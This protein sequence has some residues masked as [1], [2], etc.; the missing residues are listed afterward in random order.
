MEGHL[1]PVG[2]RMV[3]SAVSVLICLLVSWLAGLEEL[4]IY[5]SIAALQCIQPYA[6]DTWK[7][8]RQRLYGTA[9]GSVFGALAI[10]VEGYLLGIRGTLAGYVLIAAFIIPVLWAT[11]ALDKRNTA[12]FSCVVFLSIT[13]THITDAD[14]WLFVWERVSE[15]LAG[16]VVGIAVSAFQLPRRKRRDILFVSGLD[17]VLLAPQEEMTPYSR[18]RLNRML[19]DGM[20]FTIS[21]MRTP[22]SVREAVP[23]LRFRLPLI[24]MDGAAMYDMEKKTFLH[25]RFLPRELVFRCEDVLREQGIHCF[26]NGVLDDVLLIYYGELRNEAEQDIYARLHTSP[27]R[28]YIRREHYHQCPVLYLMAIDRTERMQAAYDALDHAGLLEEVKVRF[29]PAADY[30]GYSYLKIYERSASRRAMLQQLEADLGVTESVMFSSKEGEGDVVLRSGDG[31]QM[32]KMLERMYEPYLW[33]R[34]GKGRRPPD[35]D[36]GG[37]AGEGAHTAARSHR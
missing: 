16:V 24:V 3:K 36:M 10:F 25:A 7:M 21:T 6:Q 35:G 14:P 2:M 18:V 4:R 12:Y 32:V 15:T 29:Y 20:R 31:D 5:A 1:P 17:G 9:V 37:E 23:D 28:N 27:Y 34:R 13:V 22:A 11:V 30:P 26:L 33:E 8:A 19:D